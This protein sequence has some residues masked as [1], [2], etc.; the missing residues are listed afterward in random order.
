[1][2]R[3]LKLGRALRPILLHNGQ[4]GGRSL[5]GG[6]EPELLLLQGGQQ[7]A[8]IRRAALLLHGTQQDVRL[9]QGGLQRALPLLQGRQQGEMLWNSLIEGCV[10]QVQRDFGDVAGAEF[11]VSGAREKGWR[12]SP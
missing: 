2:E 10:Y 7:S 6:L 8:L 5:Q 12:G 1:G 11:S 4:Q 9:A 3:G